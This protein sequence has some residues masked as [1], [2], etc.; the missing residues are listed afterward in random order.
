M[1]VGH[2]EPVVVMQGASLNIV[3]RKAAVEGNE[4]GGVEVG[5]DCTVC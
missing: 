4:M 2:K 1:V 5:L 3:L